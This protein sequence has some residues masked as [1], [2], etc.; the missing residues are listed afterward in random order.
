M[1]IETRPNIGSGVDRPQ[2]P[3]LVRR[4]LERLGEKMEPAGEQV[5][6]EEDAA[7]K[8]SVNNMGQE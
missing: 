3:G 1:A 7:R 4:V 8:S 5:L 6:Q 2:K